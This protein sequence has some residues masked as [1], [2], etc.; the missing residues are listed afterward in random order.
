[1]PPPNSN[2][3]EFDRKIRDLDERYVMGLQNLALAHQQAKMNKIQ[4]WSN[5]DKLVNDFFT[6]SLVTLGV[7][8]TVLTAKQSIIGNYPIFY[9][10]LGFQAFV[11][12]F[13]STIRLFI[14][15]H[16]SDTG[17]KVFEEFSNRI[18]KIDTFRV[19]MTNTN[20]EEKE[21]V[22]AEMTSSF[23]PEYE[24]KPRDDYWILKNG[25]KAIVSI[26]VI[27]FLFFILSI[28]LNIGINK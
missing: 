10:A 20:K 21:R 23:A 9:I 22:R 26:F 7:M 1:M 27:G 2:N 8:A 13:S 3:E 16:A 12:I 4:S 15:V 24:F 6:F 14:N 11:I 19:A 25:Q 5:T 28:V 18:N 17:N